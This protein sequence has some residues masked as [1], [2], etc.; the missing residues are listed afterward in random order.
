MGVT[1]ETQRET[2]LTCDF[3]LLAF[4]TE[5]IRIIQDPRFLPFSAACQNLASGT[6]RASGKLPLQKL[7]L[8]SR[9][10]HYSC[11]PTSK[12]PRLRL[13][14]AAQQYSTLSRLPLRSSRLLVKYGLQPSRNFWLARVAS[15]LL[16]LRYIVLGSAVGGGYTA[17]KVPA[18][19]P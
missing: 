3:E 1:V 18:L 11:H 4:K 2:L 13:R 5:K 17:Q 12:L 7:H 9:K 15:R 8:I 14:T 6:Y 19:C 16:R 10:T